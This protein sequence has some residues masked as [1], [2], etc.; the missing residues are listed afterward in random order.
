MGGFAMTPFAV[1][2]VQM[3]IT[4]RSNVEAMQ[5]RVDLLMHLYPW[6]Q[7]VM[8][9]ELAPFGPQL[10]NAQEL[11]SAAE[12]AFQETAQKHGIWLL[13]G[14]MFERLN[15][16]IHNTASVI[17]PQGEVIARY[18]KMFPFRPYEEGVAPGDSF[19]VF[20]VPDVG[21]FGVSICYDIWFPETSRTLTA[22]GAEVLLHPVLTHTI[23]RDVE[24]NIARAAAA[25]NQCYVFDINGLLAGGNGRSIVIDPSGRTLHESSVNEELI[26]IEIDL[27]QVRW[28][29]QH[30]IRGLGQPLKSFR[31]STVDFSV[32][33]PARRDLAYLQSLGPLEKLR[34]S[35]TEVTLEPEAVPVTE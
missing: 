18:R 15:G 33:D 14:S 7:M 32:Y 2:G 17:N 11:P 6:V 34:R 24:L 5:H 30:G 27:D 8:F 20:D 19:V 3:P 22:M 13:P 23:D 29:R 28:Q 1:A 31:D 16:V 12:Q 26:P 21:R 10:Q 9:S 4:I 25:V 35:N